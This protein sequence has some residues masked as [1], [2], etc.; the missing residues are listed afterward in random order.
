MEQKHHKAY[1][2]DAVYAYFDG[3]SI[4]LTTENGVRADN[5]IVLE[6]DVVQSLIEFVE[7]LRA[8]RTAAQ[9]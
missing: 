7:R 6:P 8:A 1:L 9:S 2:G 4:I 3:F 5:T